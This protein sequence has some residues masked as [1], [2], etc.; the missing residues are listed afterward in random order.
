MQHH[1]ALVLMVL[2][3]IARNVVL[4]ITIIKTQLIVQN[5]HV[6]HI[7]KILVVQNVIHVMN[8]TLTPHL[9]MAV[10]LYVMLYI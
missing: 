3:S 8:I 5:V 6:I 1:V 10:L 9:K 4:D 2:D 7:Q